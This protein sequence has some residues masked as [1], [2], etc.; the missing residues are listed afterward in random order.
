MSIYIY[1]YVYIHTY[2]N[3]YIDIVWHARRPRAQQRLRRA[4]AD[5]RGLRQLLLEVCGDGGQRRFT[6][7]CKPFLQQSYPLPWNPT[8]T[9]P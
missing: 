5:P 3:I 8:G 6:Q 2:I 4:L 7:D 9:S 1:I